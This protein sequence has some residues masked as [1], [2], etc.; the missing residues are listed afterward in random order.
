MTPAEALSRRLAVLNLAGLA[1]FCG[2]IV[3]L[4]WGGR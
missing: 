3:V 2:I 4:A 1:F